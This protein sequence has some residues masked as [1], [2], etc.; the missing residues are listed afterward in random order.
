MRIQGFTPVRSGPL[1]L[2]LLLLS[3]SIQG[4]GDNGV[5]LAGQKKMCR[6]FLLFSFPIHG[7]SQSEKWRDKG[8]IYWWLNPI[9]HPSIN[10]EKSPGDTRDRTR[11]GAVGR[12]IQMRVS[13]G[14][15]CRVHWTG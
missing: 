10:V 4:E 1:L 6:V 7:V 3:S 15:A 14:T 13:W 12:Q 11:R 5:C 8:I 2:L 9:T